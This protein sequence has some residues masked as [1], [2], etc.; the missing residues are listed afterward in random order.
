MSLHDTDEATCPRC[1]DVLEG[2]FGPTT[3]EVGTEVRIPLECSGCEAP[4]EVVMSSAE[5]A[6]GLEVWVE[7]RRES[8]GG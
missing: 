6:I 5:D 1:G 3:P 7:D 4:L 2:D 8:N